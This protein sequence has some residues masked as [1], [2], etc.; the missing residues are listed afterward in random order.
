MKTKDVVRALLVDQQ[1]F[2]FI[3]LY[4]GER[5]RESRLYL[6]PLVYLPL[7]FREEQAVVDGPLGPL[8]MTLTTKALLP[9][10]EMDF[11]R[12]DDGIVDVQFRF[13]DVKVLDAKDCPFAN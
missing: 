12:R 6:T 5:C 7:Q 10:K 2:C 3:D 8:V 13:S 9:F 4:A 1:R 11:V